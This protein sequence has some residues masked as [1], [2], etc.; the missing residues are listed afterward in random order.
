MAAQYHPPPGSHFV[1]VVDDDSDSATSLPFVSPRH[2]AR[3]RFTVREAIST[4]P[5]AK[6]DQAK[7]PLRLLTV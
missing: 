5:A 3:A 1:L 6:S 4:A 7:S 2:H